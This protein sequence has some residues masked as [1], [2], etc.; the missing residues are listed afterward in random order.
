MVGKDKQDAAHVLSLYTI[1]L[2]IV[3]KNVHSVLS[4]NVQSLVCLLQQRLGRAKQ[5]FAQCSIFIPR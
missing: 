1:K 2:A 4:V 5:A 3:T